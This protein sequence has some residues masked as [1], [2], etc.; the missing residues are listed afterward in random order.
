MVVYF[1]RSPDGRRILFGGRVSVFEADP[2]KALPAL[3]DELLRL[4]PDLRDTPI[5]HAWMGFVAY[6]F[7]ELP[8]LGREDGI[9]YAMGYCGSGISLA[10]HF[11][12]RVGRA[13]V[14]G[15][16]TDSAFAFGRFPTRPLYRGKPW[17]LAPAV[18]YYQ[19]L[20]RFS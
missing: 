12:H 17:F 19:W 3:R 8:H 11:G 1:R 15:T 6:T 18:G 7:D 5:S 16:E 4:F 20:D 9:D 13:I 10:S 2:V 14:E